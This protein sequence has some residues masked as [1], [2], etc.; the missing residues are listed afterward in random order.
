MLFLLAKFRSSRTRWHQVSETMTTKLGELPNICF[1]PTLAMAGMN[2]IPLVILSL[3]SSPSS[4]F[5]FLVFLPSRAA[6]AGPSFLY[7]PLVTH[8][9]TL[10]PHPLPLS[11][12]PSL[13]PLPSPSIPS[14][15]PSIPSP[16]PSTPS[17]YP[18]NTSFTAKACLVS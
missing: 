1:Q 2:P 11:L 9:L 15:P 13:Y 4:L 10:H 14:P 3:P 17:F 8:P 7:L 12:T 5:L 16:P 6:K 18:S